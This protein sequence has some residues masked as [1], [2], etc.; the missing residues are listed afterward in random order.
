ML[1]DTQE[2]ELFDLNQLEAMFNYEVSV[3]MTDYELNDFCAK[4]GVDYPD[5]N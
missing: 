4:H 2:D 5:Y 1:T 3:E